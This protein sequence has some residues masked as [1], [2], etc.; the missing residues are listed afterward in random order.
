MW[1]VADRQM[2]IA[3]RIG[4]AER[5]DIVDAGRRREQPAQFGRRRDND[6]SNEC[7]QRVG[8][9]DEAQC[10]AGTAVAP[11][12]QRAVLAQRTTVPQRHGPF[13]HGRLPPTPFVFSGAF[14]EPAGGE[15]RFRQRH[16]QRGMIGLGRG[17]ALEIGDGLGGF[18][19][20]AQD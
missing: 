16:V 8:E 19:G 4:A 10:L 12:Q 3:A 14:G 7:M 6:A 9:T 18:S 2:R 20:I 1:Q 15:K 17:C 11:Q 5:D 13:W